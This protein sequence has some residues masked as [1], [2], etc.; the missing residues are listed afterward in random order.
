MAHNPVGYCARTILTANRLP[1]K[2]TLLP[3]RSDKRRHYSIPDTS[4]IV[5]SVLGQIVSG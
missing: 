5:L 1:S 4:T 3:R 2:T